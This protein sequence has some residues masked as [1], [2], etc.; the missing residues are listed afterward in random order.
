[1]QQ[2]SFLF[3]IGSAIYIFGAM[4]FLLFVNA[5]PESWGQ[6]QPKSSPVAIISSN[7]ILENFNIE[8]NQTLNLQNNNNIAIPIDHK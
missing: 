5:K 2:W 1:M 4:I 3:W 7:E 6:Q 8:K